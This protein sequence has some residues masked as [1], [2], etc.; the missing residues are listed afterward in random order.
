ML[1][2]KPNLPV[3]IINDPK[4]EFN[5]LGGD[6]AADEEEESLL[7]RETLKALKK[8]K[9]AAAAAAFKFEPAAEP[10]PLISPPPMEVSEG[11][12]RSKGG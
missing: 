12:K 7:A 10:L 11:V 1:Y 5:A 8:V 2:S 6:V 9:L 4:A 3:A